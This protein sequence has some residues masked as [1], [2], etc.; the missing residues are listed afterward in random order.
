V[1]TRTAFMAATLVWAPDCPRRL[2]RR[3]AGGAMLVCISSAAMPGE[4]CAGR[5]L[6]CSS[7]RR[8]VLIGS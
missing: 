1:D 4:R 7:K 5:V 2:V 3:F 8:V 6:P